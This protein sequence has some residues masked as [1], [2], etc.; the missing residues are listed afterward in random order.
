MS[1]VNAEEII[2]SSFRA[3]KTH[4]YAV[5]HV[6]SESGVRSDLSFQ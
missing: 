4:F 3:E 6:D 1:L 2:V 5:Q